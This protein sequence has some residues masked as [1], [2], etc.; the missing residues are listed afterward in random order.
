MADELEF[1]RML[2]YDTKDKNPHCIDGKEKRI[3]TQEEYD[4]L[5]AKGWVD[6]P[7]FPPYCWPTPDQQA[8]AAEAGTGP[9]IPET[10]VLLGAGDPVASE[11]KPPEDAPTDADSGPATNRKRK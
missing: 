9:A 1:P 8:A 6:K 10:G 11:P 2:Y 4:A 3:E 7:T 5:K